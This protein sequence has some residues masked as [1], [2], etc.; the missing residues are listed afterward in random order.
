M[1]SKT[2]S[3]NVKKGRFISIEG[4]EGCGKSTQIKRIAQRLK[5]H[6]IDCIITREPGGTDNA[7][8]IRDLLLSGGVNRWDSRTEAL[9]FAAARG[10]H[11]RNLI[12]PALDR[13]QWILCDRFV[14][15]S[16]AYQSGGSGLSDAIIMQLHDI[17]SDGFLPDRTLILDLDEDIA[18][19][20][21]SMR[22]GD[23]RDRIGGRPKEF[24]ISVRAAFR[25]YA[26][27][28]HRR[29]KLIDANADVDHVT[30]AIMDNLSD[31]I[32]G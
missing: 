15:S 11:V 23:A 30:N 4:G 10:D 17:G 18:N 12:R 21:V 1:S 13:G 25:S 26:K 5:T 27:T 2:A 20:R 6:G 32:D 8:A 3:D 19:E 14:D 24:H 29:I 22:D 7:E 9:L 31:F 16:R 28:D